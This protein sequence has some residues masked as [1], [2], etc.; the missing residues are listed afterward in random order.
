M[1][2]NCNQLIILFIILFFKRLCSGS[3][4]H[5][6]LISSWVFSWISTFNWNVNFFKPPHKQTT[7]A[8]DPLVGHC[9]KRNPLYHGKWKSKVCDCVCI[10]FVSV[11]SCRFVWE[12]I[13]SCCH[14]NH[15]RR[16]LQPPTPPTVH[17]DLITGIFYTFHQV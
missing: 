14:L 9:L 16:F 5:T 15:N 2:N 17:R 11:V 4:S 8:E 10:V 3:A 1:N 7:H 12:T 6:R 13:K